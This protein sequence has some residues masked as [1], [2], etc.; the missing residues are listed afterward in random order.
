MYKVLKNAVIFTGIVI[1]ILIILAIIAVGLRNV[2]SNNAES[3]QKASESRFVNNPSA[4]N[5]SRDLS[6]ADVAWHVKNTYGF[7]CNEVVE[8]RL[9]SDEDYYTVK[10][11]NGNRFKVFTRYK[12]HPIIERY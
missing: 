11:A 9:P 12:K 2:V 3:P 4:A 1:A 7:Y 10:C 6:K 5:T 8:R